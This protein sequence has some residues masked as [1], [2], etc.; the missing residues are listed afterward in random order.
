MEN[1]VGWIYMGYQWSRF[2]YFYFQS[3][4]TLQWPILRIMFL[5]INFEIKSL[6]IYKFWRW[7]I[8]DMPIFSYF[9]FRNEDLFLAIITTAA[10][11]VVNGHIFYCH[12][13]KVL[14][15][16]SISTIKL[17]HNNIPMKK[18]CN[19]AKSGKHTCSD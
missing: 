19:L 3:D 7:K 9:F 18:N 2:D 16:I 17:L 11:W 5:K 8:K 12:N 15:I 6:C 13:E 10:R 1:D 4:T 14:G